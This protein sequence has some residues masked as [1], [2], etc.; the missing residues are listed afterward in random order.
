VSVG[1]C[2]AVRWLSCLLVVGCTLGGPAKPIAPH[3]PEPMPSQVLD[4]QDPGAD[5]SHNKI[6]SRSE[7]HYS[8]PRDPNKVG[9]ALLPSCSTND[10]SGLVIVLAAAFTLRRRKRGQLNESRSRSSHHSRS[11][12]AQD[13]PP[14]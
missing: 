12:R 10:A 13:R 11:A 14:Q 5:T 6:L 3:D 2:L 9:C 1:Y 4:K 7:A 8:P